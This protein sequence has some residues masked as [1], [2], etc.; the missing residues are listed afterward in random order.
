M[1]DSADSFF[2][3]I[4]SVL[5]RAAAESE[6]CGRTLERIRERMASAH[7]GPR[8]ISNDLAVFT[9]SAN[10]VKPVHRRWIAAAPLQ[11][12]RVV[13]GMHETKRQFRRGLITCAEW[14]V[15]TIE[16]WWRSFF[17]D[18]NNN[19]HPLAGWILDQCLLSLMRVAVHHTA[20][21]VIES[22]DAS[23]RRQ[24]QTELEM[25]DYAQ[26]ELTTLQSAGASL[27]CIGLQAAVVVE[28]VVLAKSLAV[29]CV[30]GDHDS[31][32]EN[33]GASVAEGIRQGLQGR[34]LDDVRERID[35]TLQYLNALSFSAEM[36]A[37]AYVDDRSRTDQWLYGIQD[38]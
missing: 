16:L 7:Y 5:A 6:D 14:S 15:R 17:E 38:P 37:I 10:R 31:I 26:R 24:D 32:V 36:L 28:D 20:V 30:P 18:G 8:G 33:W 21:E 22:D 23:T 35:K 34:G 11:L 3:V 1:L 12:Q 13:D 2:D 4:G 25:K 9:F 29:F 27:A 19:W